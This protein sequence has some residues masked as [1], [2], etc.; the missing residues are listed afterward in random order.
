[1]RD[2][3]E[4][5]TSDH[6]NDVVVRRRVGDVPEFVDLRQWI[7]AAVDEDDG[8]VQ[9]TDF[10]LPGLHHKAEVVGHAQRRTLVEV[11]EH[12]VPGNTRD[13]A[14]QDIDVGLRTAEQPQQ[15]LPAY[16]LVRVVL[17]ELPVLVLIQVGTI[18]EG[19]KASVELTGEV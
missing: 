14:F 9:S 1:M 12:P 6:G 4:M 5:P 15:D 16:A 7:T 10:A 2:R 18:R 8:H 13:A 17:P 11:G 3:Y 19:S